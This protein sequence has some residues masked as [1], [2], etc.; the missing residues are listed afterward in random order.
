MDE[1]HKKSDVYLKQ[2]ER[3][4]QQEYAQA[5]SEIQKKLEDY[6]Q[7]YEVKNRVKLDKLKKGEITKAEYDYWRTGQ[8]MIGK[9]WEEMRDTIAQDLSH[10]NEIAASIINGY[11]PEVYALNHNYGTYEAEKGA[12]VDTSYTLYDRQTVERLMRSSA[13]PIPQAKVDIPKDLK[14]NQRQVTSA[15]TQSILQGESIKQASKR[16]ASV[17]AESNMHVATRNARTM[18]TSAQNAGRVDSY[19]RASEMGIKMEQVW[20]ATL[21]GRTRHSHRQ[22]DGEKIKVGGKFSNGCRY[23]GDPYGPAWEVYNCR[24]TLIGQVQGV[25]FNVTD[26]RNRNNYK[27]G[28][29]T[30]DEWKN[31]KTSKRKNNAQKTTEATK[32]KETAV[33]RAVAKLKNGEQPTYQDFIDAGAEVQAVFNDDPKVSEL[34]SEID[35]LRQEVNTKYEAMQKA[36]TEKRD[37][38]S[39]YRSLFGGGQWRWTQDAIDEYNAKKAEYERLYT[40]YKDAYN[41]RGRVSNMLSDF[42]STVIA[43]M[44]GETQ[45]FAKTIT[46]DDIKTHFQGQTRNN[47]GRVAIEQAYALYP[48]SWV[49]ASID[50][51]T[52]H[53]GSV[54]RGFCSWDGSEVMISGY[55]E[56]DKM[57]TGLHELGHRFESIF[58][59]LIQAEHDFYEYRTQGEN[60]EWLGPGYGRHETTRRDNFVDP[61]MGKDYSGRA[62]EIFSMGA[63]SVL[64]SSY[65]IAEHDPEYLNFISGLL[66]TIGR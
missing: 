5:A 38:D 48:T 50:Y 51:G 62:Y 31:D 53:T 17:T 42:R 27:L 30:Y 25:D 24:C 57:Q 56:R 59:S 14:W 44:R 29:M 66:V 34:H 13:A 46:A 55:S 39:K 16:I 61:Y 65:N 40:E 43:R 32:P 12:M 7:R 20:L 63:E 21:D 23:P 8:I 45:G 35:R 64:S 36:A 10:T 58:P 18:I 15:V 37:M 9:R 33:D 4:V 47:L 3:R 22:L 11:T 19:K 2:V 28:T 49:Q 1:A 54:S 52:I 6:L 41:S 26:I 60:L